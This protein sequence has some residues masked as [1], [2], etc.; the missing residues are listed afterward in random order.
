MAKLEVRLVDDSGRP[1]GGWSDSLVLSYA[2]RDPRDP[3]YCENELLHVMVAR[4]EGPFRMNPRN[5]YDI[6]WAEPSELLRLSNDDLGREPSDRK[7]A[8]WV[9]AMFSLSGNKAGKTLMM[10][11]PT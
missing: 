1:I 7:Y 3:R 4:Y 11:R 8:P 2:A 9:H 10:L 5:V 6:K